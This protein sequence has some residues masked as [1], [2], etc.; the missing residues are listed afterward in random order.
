MK[1][2]FILFDM[3]GVLLKS[4]GYQQ[5]LQTS[6]N[7]IAKAL[8][9]P[10]AKITSDQIAQF[11]ALSIT[12]EWDTL[13]ISIALVLVHVWQFDGSIRLTSDISRSTKSIPIESP[14]F[15]QFLNTFDDVGPLP[16]ESAFHK[17]IGENTWLNPSQKKHL[18]DILFKCR[19]IHNSLTL[20]IHQ[21]TVLGSRE[22]HA[23]YELQPQL[24]IE[25]F[26][27][28]YDQP[29]MSREL[30]SKLRAW[31]LEKNHHVGILTNRPNSTPG[32]F[33]SAPEAELGAKL[34]G[35]EDYPI[36]GSGMLNWYAETQCSL[37]QHTFLKPN[38]VHALGLMQIC[39]GQSP[40]EAISRAVEL[41]H[42]NK[43]SISHWRPLQDADV[44]IF[45]DSIKGLQSGMNAKRLLKRIDININLKC[46]GVTDN[47]IKKR[48]LLDIADEVIP[49]INHYRW[50]V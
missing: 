19:D 24:N 27:L 17:I 45:E 3:D 28:K 31:L 33:I 43:S 42:E 10:Q 2:K 29:I 1:Q 25:S 11:E 22:F 38:A 48:A 41:W 30:S 49:T 32:E 46:I 23:N 47:P 37:P 39:L 16:G 8:G 13:A 50:A 35:M 34:V 9:V 26:L 18:K 40:G 4:G 36:L 44:L 5:S 20:P 6:V 12:N 14:D 7:R 15:Q 21:E